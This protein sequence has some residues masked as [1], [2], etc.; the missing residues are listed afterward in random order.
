[1]KLFKGK[2]LKPVLPADNQL[3]ECD[4]VVYEEFNRLHVLH[5]CAL[6]CTCLCGRLTS[7]SIGS[8]SCRYFSG[9]ESIDP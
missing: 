3:F 1:V 4:Y 9:M 5:I 7:I 6:G 2:R 8:L